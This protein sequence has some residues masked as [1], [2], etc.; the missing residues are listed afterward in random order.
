M[1]FA[2]DHEEL[3]HKTDEHC[4]AKARKECLWERFAIASTDSAHNISRASTDMNS[5]ENSM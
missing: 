3:Y 4:K 2:K 5:M 1:D